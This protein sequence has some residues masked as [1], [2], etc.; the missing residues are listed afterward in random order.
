MIFAEGFH[1][2]AFHYNWAIAG[3]FLNVTME[4]KKTIFVKGEVINQARPM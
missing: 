3:F 1:F 4:F 2:S